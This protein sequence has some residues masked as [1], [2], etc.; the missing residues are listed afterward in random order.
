MRRMLV[1]FGLAALVAAVPCATPFAAEVARQPAR[2][3]LKK[4]QTI[5]IVNADGSGLKKLAADASGAAAAVSPDGALIAYERYVPS[6]SSHTEI[7]LLEVDG[8][9]VRATGLRDVVLRGWSADKRFLLYDRYDGHESLFDVRTGKVAG[10]VG[11]PGCCDA[12]GWSPDGRRFAGVVEL[13]DGPHGVVVVDWATRKWRWLYRGEVGFADPVWSPNAQAVAFTL[14]LDTTRPDAQPLAV[15]SVRTGRLTRVGVTGPE[16]E[17]TGWLAWAP[18]PRL[19]FSRI[20]GKDRVSLFSWDGARV[21]RLPIEGSASDARWSPEGRMLAFRWARFA[22]AYDEGDVAVLR[23]GRARRITPLGVDGDFGLVGWSRG[24]RL[25]AAAPLRGVDLPAL[26][27]LRVARAGPLDARGGR[28]AISGPCGPL[29]LWGVDDHT[30]LTVPPGCSGAFGEVVELA[31]SRSQAAWVF[32]W[33]DRDRGQDC[34]MVADA[35]TGARSSDGPIC[36]GY[37]SKQPT[38][39]GFGPGDVDAIV[40]AERSIA[41]SSQSAYDV[42]VFAIG[43]AGP[44]RLAVFGTLLAYDGSRFVVRRGSAAEIVDGNGRA[45][46]LAGPAPSEARLVEDTLV[47]IGADGALRTYDARRGTVT[48]TI[49]VRPRPVDRPRLEDAVAGYAALAVD[50]QLRIVRLA[51][52]RSV[53]VALPNGVAPVHARFMGARLVVSYNALGAAPYGRVVVVPLAAV[54]RTLARAD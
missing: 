46:R 51:D 45:L 14:S 17:R 18:G 4:E 43:A 3:V 25:P 24:P 35:A 47:A 27:T 23:G 37:R 36:G 21:R 1:V 6:G 33:W 22:S 42:G 31:L 28:V 2:I 41:Y 38:Y 9:R 39:R 30:R 11:P 8:G 52:G 5:Y 10:S 12:V 44:R 29:V 20:V 49:R 19:V 53:R 50:G 54:T 15:A 13:A 26:T 7:F 34:L 48:R 40:G 32:R 16:Q